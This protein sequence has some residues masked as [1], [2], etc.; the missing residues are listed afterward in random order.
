M[1][2][3]QRL[4]AFFFSLLG[5]SVAGR[6]LGSE[7]LM[8]TGKFWILF[9]FQL[10]LF[11]SFLFFSLAAFDLFFFIYFHFSVN[12]LLC[13]FST[14]LLTFSRGSSCG[15]SLLFHFECGGGAGAP[16]SGALWPSKLVLVEGGFLRVTGS[17]GIF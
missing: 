2:N 11:V 14:C 7:G 16:S 13:L 10:D 8:I 17:L 6:F 4:L 15:I 12:F 1:N 3:Q 9:A 5:S